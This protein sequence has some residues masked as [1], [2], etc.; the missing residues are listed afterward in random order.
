MLLI[1]KYQIKPV[2]NK[3]YDSGRICFHN[4]IVKY[5]YE[6]SKDDCF[7]NLLFYGNDGCGKTTI[8]NILLYYLYG[9]NIY[10][11]INQKYNINSNNSNKIELS[12]KQ[13]LHH[14]VINPYNNN[15]DK[16]IIQ[17]IVQSY[18]TQHPLNIN[19]NKLF[20]IVVIN[21]IEKLSYSVQ[22]SLRRTMEKYANVCRFIF[23]CNSI[24]KIIDPLK[25]RCISIRIPNPLNSEIINTLLSINILEQK[26]INIKDLLNIVYNSNNNIKK[27]II[28]LDL[29]Y[30]NIPITNS[31]DDQLYQIIKL[32]KLKL[33][34]KLE[35]IKTIIYNLLTTNISGSKII[36]DI[37]KLIIQEY[38]WTDMN[39][40]QNIVKIATKFSI[41]INNSRRE[42]IH[43]ESFIN[44][45][46]IYLP[47]CDL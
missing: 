3:C 14:L 12:I 44:Y 46:I 36:T 45:L 33:F 23:S 40:L 39:T 15:F 1:D 4:N 29:Y 6:I 9:P 16:Y 30:L 5:L 7:P 25:S 26:K 2:T 11:L 17:D 37:T 13:S 8:I 41:M 34:S 42:I 31:Y 35:N 27:A 10:K 32:I 38:K 21:N 24:S 19:Q 47:S 20:K 18:A 43:I 28:M 22:M